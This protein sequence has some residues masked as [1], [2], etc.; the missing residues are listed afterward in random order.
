VTQ[1]RGTQHADIERND[2]AQDRKRWPSW[3][4]ARPRPIGSPIR[5]PISDSVTVTTGTLKDGCDIAGVHAKTG[6]RRIGR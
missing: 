6:F 3:I 5:M 2:P 4:S 1:R